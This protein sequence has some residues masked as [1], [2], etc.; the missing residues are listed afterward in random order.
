MFLAR[1]EI[2]MRSQQHAKSLGRSPITTARTLAPL[3]ASKYLPERPGVYDVATEPRRVGSVDILRRH[4]L[5][6]ALGR[7]ATEQIPQREE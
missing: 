6:A 3:H 5:Q 1:C 7:L 4:A 2:E